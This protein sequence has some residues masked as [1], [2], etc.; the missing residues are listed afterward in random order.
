MLNQ[1]LNLFAMVHRQAC[2]RSHH[3]STTVC[4]SPCHSHT[5]LIRSFSSLTCESCSD[6]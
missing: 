1:V 5:S 4:C 2:R 6:R 3:S